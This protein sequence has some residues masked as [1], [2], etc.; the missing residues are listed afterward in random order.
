MLPGPIMVNDI[1]F[2]IKVLKSYGKHSM[3]I[4]IHHADN[5]EVGDSIPNIKYP[6]VPFCG[7]M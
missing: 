5:I 1:V 7:N 6:L 2:Y 3:M 4:C